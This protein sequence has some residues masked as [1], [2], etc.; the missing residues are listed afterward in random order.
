[1]TY[2]DTKKGVISRLAS[3]LK[4]SLTIE[5]SINRAY[6][7]FGSMMNS[8]VSQLYEKLGNTS[9]HFG[10][11]GERKINNVFKATLEIILEVTSRLINE[12]MNS[13]SIIT[14]KERI[15]TKHIDCTTYCTSAFT[16]VERKFCTHLH[17]APS[18]AYFPKDWPA[19]KC[20]NCS[21]EPR[22]FWDC[23]CRYCSYCNPTTC[24]CAGS[25]INR[26]DEVS[27]AFLDDF[28]GK[29]IDTQLA[30]TGEKKKSTK[31]RDLSSEEL[32]ELT[33]APDI[34]QKT[35][36][37][38]MELMEHITKPRESAPVDQAIDASQ[39]PV[40][41]FQPPQNQKKT[42][43]GINQKTKSLCQFNCK[44]GSD[45]CGHHQPK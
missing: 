36:E 7:Y 24:R 43:K 29:I 17:G 11:F 23:G 33:D 37:E 4:T 44:P 21:S 18:F 16:G 34:K 35:L 22:I 38:L 19:M 13:I 9:N 28:N 1:M 32:E 30:Y 31:S 45:F 40:N 10:I 3:L 27:G 5:E 41:M 2:Y 26:V 25:M 42:C 15:C 6:R 8:N 39:P 20:M 12:D 14:G